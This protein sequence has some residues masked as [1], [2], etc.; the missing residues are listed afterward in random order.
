MNSATY[1]WKQCRKVAINN[2]CHCRCRECLNTQM[3]ANV[4]SVRKKDVKTDEPYVEAIDVLVNVPSWMK[5]SHH[6]KLAVI[7][8]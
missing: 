4:F 2:N 7:R 1:Y 8:H 6:A 3:S 5:F